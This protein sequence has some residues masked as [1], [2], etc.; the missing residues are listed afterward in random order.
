MDDDR[1]P[2][3]GP[4][5]PELAGPAPTLPGQTFEDSLVRCPWCGTEHDLFLEPP[6]DQPDQIYYEECTTCGQDYRVVIDWGEDGSPLI[7]VDRGGE[8]E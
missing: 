4:D 8:N 7:R 3:T 5:D 2:D 1:I 6:A